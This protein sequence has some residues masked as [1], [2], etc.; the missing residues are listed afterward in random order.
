MATGADCVNTRVWTT[1]THCATGSTCTST[2][3]VVDAGEKVDDSSCAIIDAADDSWCA[4]GS[5]CD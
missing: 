3:C 2:V 1:D 5:Y 4:V